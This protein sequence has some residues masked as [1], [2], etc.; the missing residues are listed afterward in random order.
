MLCRAMLSGESFTSRSAWVLIGGSRTVLVEQAVSLAMNLPCHPMRTDVLWTLLETVLEQ[1]ASDS[2]SEPWPV[3]AIAQH[4]LDLHSGDHYYKH[5]FKTHSISN[6]AKY[7]SCW[8][9]SQAL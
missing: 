6:T 3:V 7:R 2:V 4:L 8:Q 1:E 9:A 5:W